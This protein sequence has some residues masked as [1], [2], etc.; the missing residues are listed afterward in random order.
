MMS[1]PGT[2]MR[3]ISMSAVLILGV[4][5]GTD[6]VRCQ[7]FSF[8]HIPQA[9]RDVR[10][11]GIAAPSRDAAFSVG[12]DGV[13]LGARAVT[14]RWDGIA[15]KWFVEPAPHPGVADS[16]FGVDSISAGDAWAVGLVVDANLSTRTLTEHW[17][18]AQWQLVASPD[19]PGSATSALLDVSEL[20]P[21]DVWAV[22]L[23]SQT[24]PLPFMPLAMH[25][26]G[27]RWKIAATPPVDEMGELRGVTA[28][29]GD[30]VWAVGDQGSDRSLTLTLHWNGSAWAVVPSPTAS[31]TSA[32]SLLDVSAASTSDIWAVGRSVEPSHPGL[33]AQTL[34]LHWDGVGM[35]GDSD[36]QSR[37]PQ[38]AAR[39]CGI[40]RR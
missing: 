17:D 19:V 20:A 21:D 9:G 38:R 22:G 4:V 15:G 24:G 39:R 34:A 3:S 23:S 29:S 30:D 11:L 35:G 6:A 31:N 16:L 32:D 25:W 2:R 28:L 12:V 13:D 18:G 37:G 10:L 5:A 7:G 8:V 27:E 14:E 26:N 33:G 1:R 36:P 40:E